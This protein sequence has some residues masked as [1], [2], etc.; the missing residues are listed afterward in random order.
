M[1]PP[2]LARHHSISNGWTRVAIVLL[3]ILIAETRLPAAAAGPATKAKPRL[4][5]YFQSDFTDASYQKASFEK[6]LKSWAPPA[7]LPAPGKKTVVQSSIGREGKLISALVT[8]KS[9]STAWDAAAL[10]AVRKAS[11]FAPL[12]AAYKGPQLEVHWH[13]ETQP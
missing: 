8:M 12:P 9:G 5:V 4:N 2:L 1:E 11:P 10:A 7:A 13:F 6:V 3:G